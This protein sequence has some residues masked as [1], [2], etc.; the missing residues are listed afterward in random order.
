MGLGLESSSGPHDHD[1][2]KRLGKMDGWSLLV[3]KQKKCPHVFLKLA[4]DLLSHFVEIDD[5]E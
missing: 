1:V 2:A 5:D 3:W 4:N